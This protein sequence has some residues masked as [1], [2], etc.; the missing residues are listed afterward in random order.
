MHLVD[1]AH[2]GVDRGRVANVAA[3]ELDIGTREWQSA[4]RGAG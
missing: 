2:G 3:D 1:A 4:S